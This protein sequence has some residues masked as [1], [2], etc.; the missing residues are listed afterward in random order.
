MLLVTKKVQNCSEKIFIHLF[1]LNYGRVPQSIVNYVLYHN[2][3]YYSG[4]LI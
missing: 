3:F 2:I 4:T 1:I